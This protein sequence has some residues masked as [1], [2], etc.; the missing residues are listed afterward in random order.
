MKKL[1]LMTVV[2]LSIVFI[3]KAQDKK[4]SIGLGIGGA[5]VSA[6]ANGI[7]GSGIG[8]NFYLNGMY[9]LTSNLSAGIEYNSS[10]AVVA[11]DGLDSDGLKATGIT[12]IL[13]KGKYSI[14][15]GGVRPYA[16][17]M[18]GMYTLTPPEIT[19]NGVVQPT[20]DK[21]TNFGFAPEIGVQF[22]GFQIGTSYH[23]P[24]KS[25]ENAG[26]VSYKVW[27]FNI[28]WNIGLIPN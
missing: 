24:G 9:N 18:L 17:A 16:G 22:G 20:G 3:G 23:F 6:D 21:K 27:Q 15:D 26:D 13:A 19:I 4:I 14:G 25:A 1:F 11:I 28:G 7:K 12:G 2:F 5:S 8:L 10:A